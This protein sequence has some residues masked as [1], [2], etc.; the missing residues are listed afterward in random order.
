MLSASNLYD[1]EYL[2]MAVTGRCTPGA[3][4]EAV[5]AENVKRVLHGGP[6]VLA[7]QRT[8]SISLPFTKH[9]SNKPERITLNDGWLAIHNACT[10]NCNQG[11]ACKCR[12][13]AEMAVPVDDIP[14]PP[15]RSRWTRLLRDMR[16][17]LMSPRAW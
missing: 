11:R 7:S 9:V 1:R 16:R 15:R 13:A 4:R 6:D 12:P 5:T 14:K 3:A 2:L 10:G 8:A 17:F